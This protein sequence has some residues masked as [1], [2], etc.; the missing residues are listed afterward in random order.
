MKTLIIILSLSTIIFSCRQQESEKPVFT[1]IDL[2]WGNGWTK[3]ISVYIDSTKSVKI[4][5]DELNQRKLYYEGQLKDSVFSK[6]NTLIQTVLKQKTESEIGEPIVDGGGSYI[7]IN[8][9][10]DNVNC[11]VYRH[12]PVITLDTIINSLINLNNYTL[13]KAADTSFVFKSLI[14][15]KPPMLDIGTIKFVPPVIKDDVIEK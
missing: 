2:S 4:S 1:K 6:L 8:S 14:K 7:I 11:A 5:V 9:K 15:I 13:H 3:I 10:S 12:E